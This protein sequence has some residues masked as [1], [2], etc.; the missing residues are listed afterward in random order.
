MTLEVG[1]LAD[2]VYT[3]FDAPWAASVIHKLWA[4]CDRMVQDVRRVGLISITMSCFTS[5]HR[6][7]APSGLPS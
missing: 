1:T 6:L 2:R 7:L 3:L 5:Y 4:A